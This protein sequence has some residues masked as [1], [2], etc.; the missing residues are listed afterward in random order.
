LSVIAEVNVRDQSGAQLAAAKP[1]APVYQ[2]AVYTKL[3][4]E[5]EDLVK[6]IIAAN[7]GADN[8]GASSN[9]PAV[10]RK[11]QSSAAHKFAAAHSVATAY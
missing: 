1:S 11:N 10:A 9:S 3:D 8:S 7:R 5:A 6:K 2:T 4:R